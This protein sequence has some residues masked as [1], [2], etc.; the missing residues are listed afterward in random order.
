MPKWYEI[1]AAVNDTAEVMIYDEIGGWG[2]QA[3]QFIN[4]LSEVTA[5]NIDL[6]LNTPGGSVFDGNA[7]YNALKRHPANITSYIDGLAASMGSIIA[8]AG[9]QVVMADNAMYMI[10]NPWTV[11]YGDA[12]EFRKTADTLDKLKSSMVRIYSEKTGLSEDD[13]TSL[14]N[15]E[16]WYT[17]EE[18]KESG[19][20]DEIEEG[21]Q[22]AANFKPDKFKS[23]K[24]TPE[25]L[26]KAEN[27]EPEPEP[28]FAEQLVSLQK[29]RMTLTILDR[30]PA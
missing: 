2:I 3:K 20:A 16:T 22:A 21:L 24:N 11:A 18:A 4:D 29:A 28:D 7:I 25:S 26:L 27:P 17:A 14:M 8:L 10:H 12:G 6:R 19:F 30:E 15:D 1:K 13:V 5:K 9:Q 23:Y